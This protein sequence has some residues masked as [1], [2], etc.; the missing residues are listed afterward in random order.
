MMNCEQIENK[1]IAYV[2]GKAN[3]AERRQVETHLAGCVACRERAEQFHLL[4]GVLDELPTVAPSLSFD[5]S[6]R[7]RV[8][9]EP[10]RAGLWSWLVPSPRMALATATLMVFSVWLSSFQPTRQPAAPVAPS[11]QSSEA[12]FGMIKDLPVLEDYDVLANF[13][14]LSELPVQPAAQPQTQQH[15]IRQEM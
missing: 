11:A 2:D 10:P 8:A 7:A 9:Q 3:P 12:E 13:D 14:A 4:W 1:F 6:L 15:Q 5:A